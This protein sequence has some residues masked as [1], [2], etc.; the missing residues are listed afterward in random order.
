MVP[1]TVNVESNTMG[2]IPAHPCYVCTLAHA[3][4]R[5]YKTVLMSHHPGVCRPKLSPSPISRSA[6]LNNPTV[7]KKDPLIAELDTFRPWHKAAPWLISAAT[8]LALIVIF[9]R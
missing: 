8:I 6:H 5:F 9:H 2:I 4:R 7:V 1:R 3:V